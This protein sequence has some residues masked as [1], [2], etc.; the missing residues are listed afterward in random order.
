MEAG[1]TERPVPQYPIESVDRTLRLLSLLAERSELKLSEVRAHLGIGQST[2]HRLL[3]MLV[4]RGFAVQDPASRTYRIG[5]AMIEIGRTADDGVDLVRE[6]RPVLAWLS[7]ESGETVHLGVL[8]RSQVHYL[9]VIESSLILR[10]TGRVG[11]TRPAHAT[12]IGKAMLAV[13]DDDEVRSLYRGG[14]LP[15]QTAHTI[16]DLD[17][18]L[19]ELGRTRSRGYGRNRG[20]MEPGVCSVAVA[21]VAPTRRLL[22]GLSIAAPQARWSAAVERA[23]VELLRT[24]AEKVAVTTP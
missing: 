9:D 6:V 17:S 23:H 3:A 16:T 8:D 18:L 20:E 15:S 12:S 21:I 13:S 10:V 22:G 2:A 1:D 14:V 24:A 19:A 4:Y 7:Q 5:P 11:Q